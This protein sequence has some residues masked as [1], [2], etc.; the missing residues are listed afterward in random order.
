[1]AD[2]V[3]GQLPAY[4]LWLKPSGPSYELLSRTIIRLAREL[5][6]PVF[7]PHITLAGPLEGAEQELVD[8]CE[9]LQ[10]VL[11]PFPIVLDEPLHGPDYFR[12]IFM[13][14]VPDSAI[15]RANLTARTV[16]DLSEAPYMPHLSLVY[17]TFPKSER[18]LIV[19]TLPRD[20]RL[21]FM[22]QGFDLIRSNSSDPKDWH[23]VHSL[24]LAQNT[25]LD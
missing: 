24:P 4:H 3:S 13:R 10:R 14:A 20:L 25:P 17:G 2:N 7:D 23:T 16:F 11:G 15:M 5:H 9:H 19:S 21:S 22:A 6:A 1:M 12:C 8:K 18:Q